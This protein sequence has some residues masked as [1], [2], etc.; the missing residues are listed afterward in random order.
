M[1]MKLLN[2]KDIPILAIMPD[3]LKKFAV[4]LGLLLLLTQPQF[5][6]FLGLM[7]SFMQDG[8]NG[9]IFNVPE[10]GMPNIHR[11]SVGRYLA[12]SPWSTSLIIAVYQGFVIRQILIHA[13][14]TGCPVFV[15]LDDTVVEHAKPSPNALNP[16]EGCGKH[17]SNLKKRTVYGHQIAGVLLVCD[18]LKLP[19][20]LEVYD[21]S[22]QSK[23]E[24]ACNAIKLLPKFPT[25]V[26]WAT[27]GIVV[28]P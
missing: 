18:D 10:Y 12:D 2:K 11:T 9:K 4:D 27:D 3:Q 24:M 17:W 19:L 1:K 26:F 14:K 7:M 20:Y 21:K 8:F 28:T 13:K 15:I 6:H 25:Q 5:F 22:K 16:I 23:I